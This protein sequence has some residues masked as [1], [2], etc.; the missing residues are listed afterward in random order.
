MRKTITVTP[1]YGR[2]Y[3]NQAEVIK[4]WEA[5]NDFTSADMASYGLAVNQEDAK[6]E[7]FTQVKLRYAKT[8][9]A[10]I[11]EIK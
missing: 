10:V 9:K 7:G 2:D 11:I 5:G 1:R 6:R 8:T 3:K 4:A